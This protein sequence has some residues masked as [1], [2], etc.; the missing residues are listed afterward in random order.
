MSS[1]SVP[2]DF[3]SGGRGLAP[4]GAHGTPSLRD[5]LRQPAAPAVAAFDFNGAAANAETV[6]IGTETWTKLAAAPDPFQFTGGTANAQA[7]S[8]GAA[9]NDDSAQGLTAVVVTDTVFVFADVA[10]VAGNL[11]ITNGLTNVT[12]P[13]AME[14]GADA[15]RR[16]MI[17][18]QHAPNASEVAAGEIHIPLPFVPDLWDVKVYVTATGAEKNAGGTDHANYDGNVTVGTAPNRLIVG[19]G[20]TLAWAATDTLQIK[21]ISE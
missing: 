14:H 21:I 13:A 2:D 11:T 4:R 8:F 12:A 7:V 15:K 6:Q 19:Q 16:E 18:L 20:T 9:V 3:G 10:G 17:V 5:F 1:I